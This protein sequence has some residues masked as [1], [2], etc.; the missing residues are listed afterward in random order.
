MKILIAILALALA[1]PTAD[2]AI[3][4]TTKQKKLP[5]IADAYIND[6]LTTIGFFITSAPTLD[7]YDIWARIE[8]EDGDEVAEF[9]VHSQQLRHKESK[10]GSAA[11]GINVRDIVKYEGEGTYEMTIFAC[12]ANLRQ[13]LEKTCGFAKKTFEYAEA[14][15]LPAI[16]KISFTKTFSTATLTLD[17]E[18]SELVHLYYGIMK[19]SGGPIVDVGLTS[20]KTTKITDLKKNLEFYGTGTY[21]LEFY[22]CSQDAT[23]ISSYCNKT[24]KKINFTSSKKPQGFIR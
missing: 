7:A 6:D 2:A 19:E 17:E 12:P 3:I 5:V 15:D 22:V 23:S 14:P 16:A 24:S 1:V 13:P 20:K 4:S 8:D 18:P 21:T 10:L 11:Y 9:F